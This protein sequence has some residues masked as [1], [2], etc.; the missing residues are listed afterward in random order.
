MDING[1]STNNSLMFK[2]VNDI[3]RQA[4]KQSNNK[5][6]F[7]YWPIQLVWSTYQ[8]SHDFRKCHN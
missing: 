2:S 3:D 8:A 1:V 7:E 5:L 4:E 6:L